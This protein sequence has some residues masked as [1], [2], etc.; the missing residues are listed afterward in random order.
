MSILKN[1]FHH[2][3]I[4][5]SDHLLVQ[6]IRCSVAGGTAFVVDFFTLAF[7]TEICGLHYILSN[8][9]SF[10]L[11]LFVNY[12]ITIF[13]VFTND[14]RLNRRAEFL[15]FAVIGIVGLG[16]TNLLLWSF[17]NLLSIYYL[18]SKII[19]AGIVYIWS[20]LAKKY[21]LFK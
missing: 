6:F 13:W 2:L 10:T 8:T 17:T 12:F 16:L 14:Y 15:S 20:F 19:S 9:V 21:W 7:L 1:S 18:L 5:K 4:Q 3:F 11:G